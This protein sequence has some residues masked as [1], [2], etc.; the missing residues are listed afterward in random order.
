MWRG[1]NEFGNDLGFDLIR[2]APF[3]KSGAWGTKTLTG[4]TLLPKEEPPLEPLTLAPTVAAGTARPLASLIFHTERHRA[5]AAP[6]ARSRPCPS[7]NAAECVIT[8]AAHSPPVRLRR[9]APLMGPDVS[10]AQT[11]S[12]LRVQTSLRA[13]WAAT[14]APQAP[15]GWLPRGPVRA[16]QPC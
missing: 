6:A 10:G 3:F 15:C 7:S 14:T 5:R 9:N 4:G 2:I 16:R 1:K 13:T 8:D 12:E 11:L